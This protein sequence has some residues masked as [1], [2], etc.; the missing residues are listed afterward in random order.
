MK[1]KKSQI[2]PLLKVAFPN[3]AGRKFSVEFSSTVQ[4]Y[5]LNW[6]G[7]TKNAYVVISMGTGKSAEVPTLAP[8][9]NPIEG[10]V[11]NLTEDLIVAQHC[12]FC[13]QDCGI[14]FYA[15]PCR[16]QAMLGVEV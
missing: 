5:D 16:Q 4:F 9:S 11:V 10:A 7:G 6:D 3:Y 2:A 12:Y 1:V 15:H 14:T 13:G 8:W